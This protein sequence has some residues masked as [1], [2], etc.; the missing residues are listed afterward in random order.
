[1]ADGSERIAKR[2]ARAGVASRRDAERLI[3]DGHVAVNGKR[4]DSPALNVTETD[5]IE[6]RGAPLPEAAPT[7]LWRYHKPTGL[8]TTARDE[9]GRKTVFDAL[10]P[11]MGRVMSIGRLDLN[12]E[13]LL[14]L[15]ND[16][17]LKR[18]LELPSTGWTRKYRVRVKGDAE[19]AA[20]ETL[21]KGI[22][23]DGETFRPMTVT[24]DQQRGTNAW[25]TMGLREGKNREIRRA[26][27]AVGLEVN[28]LIRVS[29][30]PFQLLDLK[31]GEV[32]DVPARVIRDQI[33]AERVTKPKRR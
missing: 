23:V 22:K 10:P 24:L 5:R 17:A 18:R 9:K 8:V 29:Y 11:D 14:L 12:S 21:R 6:V 31:P 33:G 3:A 28:R 4:I 25:L 7:K 32:V 30:G 26:M 1:M 20:L 27:N 19:S 15:T 16:G 13:G 2:I